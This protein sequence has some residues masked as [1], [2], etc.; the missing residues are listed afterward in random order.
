MYECIK[1]IKYVFKIVFETMDSLDSLLFYLK[2][3][4]MLL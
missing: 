1:I 4:Y 2:T 3:Q